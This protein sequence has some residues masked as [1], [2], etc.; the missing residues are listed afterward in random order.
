MNTCIVCGKE[1]KNKKYCS[2]KCKYEHMTHKKSKCLNCGKEVA[3]CEVKY[4][5]Q[6]CYFEHRRKVFEDGLQYNSCIVCGKPTLNA[7]YCSM[8]CLGQD[9]TRIETSI[10]NLPNDNPWTQKD[11]AFLKDNYMSMSLSDL[12]NKLMRTPEAV[13]AYARKHNFPKRRYWSDEDVRLLMES[14]KDIHIVA[15]ELNKSISSVFNKYAILNGFRNSSGSTIISPQEYITQYIQNDLGYNCLTEVAIGPYHMD[16]V[17]LDLDIEVQGS[18]W[19]KNPR[20]LSANHKVGSKDVVQR[21]KIRKDFIEK[22]GYQVI[23][24]WEY[25]IVTKPD[26]IKKQIKEIIEDRILKTTKT[27][28]QERIAK[29]KKELLEQIKKEEEKIRRAN[30]QISQLKNNL[31]FIEKEEEV[32]KGW[33]NSNP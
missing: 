24:L 11:I 30:A 2:N 18:Y 28:E 17:Y 19:H 32:I 15:K 26:E 10:K 6:K 16:I 8:K 27:I 14:T 20:C 25:D 31:T 22:Q 7:K 33:P 4:C 3:R 29:H 1:T 13:L 23:Y 5:S 9:K 12:A 21:D